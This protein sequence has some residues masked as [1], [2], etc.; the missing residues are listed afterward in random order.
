MYITTFT[1]LMWVPG[2]SIVFD[3][4]LTYILVALMAVILNN[5][6]VERLSLH[7]RITV[8]ESDMYH[9]RSSCQTDEIFYSSSLSLLVMLSNNLKFARRF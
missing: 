1:A 6:L 4:S 7:T 9:Q 2:T 5:I 8:G 3:M